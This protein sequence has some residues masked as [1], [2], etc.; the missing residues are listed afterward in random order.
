MANKANLSKQLAGALRDG[1][2]RAKVREV[3][4]AEL[5]YD[6]SN[7][8][9]H[10]AVRLDTACALRAEIDAIQARQRGGGELDLT[11]LIAAS[12]ALSNILDQA[13]AGARV[14]FICLPDEVC[15]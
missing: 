4:A 8:K 14:E 15:S 7:L 5:R 6:I 10:E 13:A 12:T 3:L 2:E 9:P 1:A 11:R